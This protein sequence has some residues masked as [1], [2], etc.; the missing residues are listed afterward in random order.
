MR[1][2]LRSC[3][4]APVTS[5]AALTSASWTSILAA[6]VADSDKGGSLT[7]TPLP[8]SLL[9]QPQPGPDSLGSSPALTAPLRSIQHLINKSS[10]PTQEAAGLCPR[11]LLLSRPQVPGEPEQTVCLPDSS[12]YT[13][14][15]RL[16]SI[17]EEGFTRHCAPEE[18]PRTTVPTVSG[19]IYSRPP[20]SIRNS[21]PSP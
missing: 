21:S 11:L 10:W 2:H 5:R 17:H 6:L 12:G 13:G 4:R 14:T 1:G 3:S 16:L 18:L 20:Q 19:L 8:T 9:A 15:F 7:C